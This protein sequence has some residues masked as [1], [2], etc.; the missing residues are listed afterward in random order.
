MPELS[1]IDYLLGAVQRK[2]LL[3][4]NCYF[5]ALNNKYE[6]VVNLYEE[7][8]I[9]KLKKILLPCQCCQHPSRDEICRLKTF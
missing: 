1:I 4:E 6:T 5:E 9:K 2:L 7:G 3:N 8:I